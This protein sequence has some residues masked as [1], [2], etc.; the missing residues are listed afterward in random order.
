MY[1]IEFFEV[2]NVDATLTM[3]IFILCNNLIKY[4]HLI[5]NISRQ[6]ESSNL[7]FCKKKTFYL[8]LALILR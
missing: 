5:D 3:C 2:D 8:P 1:I 7:S 4:V 6:I